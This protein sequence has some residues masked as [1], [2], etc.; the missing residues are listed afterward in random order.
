MSPSRHLIDATATEHPATARPF[1]HPDPQTAPGPTIGDRQPQQSHHPH[2]PLA[3]WPLLSRLLDA[4]DGHS[5]K[6]RRPSWHDV[7]AMGVQESR[8]K[9]STLNPVGEREPAAG[10]LPTFYQSNSRFPK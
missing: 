6:S 4:F 2:R 8:K 1:H 10:R 9:Q 5:A 7:A 3:D